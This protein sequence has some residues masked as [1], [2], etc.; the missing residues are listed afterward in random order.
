M[1]SVLVPV[2][3]LLLVF[4]SLLV[5]SSWYRHRNAHKAYEPYFP[6]HRE[7][8]VYVSLIQKTDPPASDTLLKAAL[9]RRAMT[10]VSRI[11]RIREDKPALQ[12]L[13][14]K[15]SIGDDLW[16]SLLAAEKELEAEILE[17]AAEANTFVEGWGQIIFQTATEM[18]HNERMRALLEQ[19]PTMRAAKERK[20]GRTSVPKV[21]NVPSSSAAVP[22]SVST[23][24]KT[25][26]SPVP[27]DTSL[28]ASTT[29]GSTPPGAGA[30]SVMSDGEGSISP[31]SP[32]TPSKSVSVLR[33]TRDNSRSFPTCRSPQ[34]RRR[35]ENKYT[36]IIPVDVHS[37][38]IAYMTENAVVSRLCGHIQFREWQQTE[39]VYM[40]RESKADRTTVL[41][42]TLMSRQAQS[43]LSL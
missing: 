16:N 22:S 27:P 2:L 39:K 25:P 28:P 14:Q 1:A 35:S 4:G 30:E 37:S 5:F 38:R 33:M 19:L 32:R 9:V 18:L 12:V 23:A 3:Y 42:T 31:T 17:V 11:L 40:M 26:V 36:V 24:S 34:K 15:G 21:D 6:P 20:Y 41:S 13:L 43:I 8:D 10:D 7:R 29:N